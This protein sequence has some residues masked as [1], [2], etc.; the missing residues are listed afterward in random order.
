MGKRRNRQKYFKDK[1]E[2]MKEK[3]PKKTLKNAT[4]KIF[5]IFIKNFQLLWIRGSEDSPPCIRLTS[6][7]TQI[8]RQTFKIVERMNLF[9]QKIIKMD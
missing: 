6:G 4:L 7:R 3:G 1:I 5:K 9:K 8:N 2:L